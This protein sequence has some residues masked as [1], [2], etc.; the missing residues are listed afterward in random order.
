[1]SIIVS[2]SGEVEVEK[3]VK[4]CKAIVFGV[5]EVVVRVEVLLLPLLLLDGVPVL[6]PQALGVQ[7]IP[8]K[9]RRW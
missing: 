3:T 1:M 5:G 8:A 9:R 6:V 2:G 7:N 4:A